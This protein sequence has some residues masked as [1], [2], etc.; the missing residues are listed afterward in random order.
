MDLKKRW[1]YMGSLVS[2]ELRNG[3]AHPYRPY[4]ERDHSAI[5]MQIIAPVEQAQP[6]DIV[7]VIAFFASDD[8]RFM[9]GVYAPV[10]AGL[11]MD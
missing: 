8:S 2:F 5:E 6:E 3:S 10:N 11:T 4:C 7:H 1:L 9:T